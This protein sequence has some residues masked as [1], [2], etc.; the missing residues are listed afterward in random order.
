MVEIGFRMQDGELSYIK[1]EDYIMVTGY[2]GTSSELIIPE[3]IE[4]LPVTHIAKKAFLSKKYLRTVSLPNSLEEV[5][6]WC[7]AYCYNLEQIKFP[8]KCLR[9]GKSIFLE[10][11]KLSKISVEKGTEELLA[12]AVR[13][14]KSYYLLNLNEI[15]S[16]EWYTW[17]DTKCL[18]FVRTEDK[19][20]YVKQILCGEDEVETSNFDVYLSNKRKL[21]SNLVILRLFHDEHLS[22]ENRDIL[23]D[24]IKFHTKGCAQE[25]AW[26]L[27]ISDYCDKP[28]YYHLF[29]HLG[30]ITKENIDGVLADISEQHAEMKAFMLR[31]K[32]EKIGYNDFFG[33]MGLD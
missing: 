20:G 17:W 12:A 32:K 23:Q 16:K 11:N 6:G 10:C 29:A 21:K 1:N 18:E 26:E 25:E 28:E 24:Y 27:M 33:A 31:F 2:T 4:G 15:G 19:D 7:F 3:H 9:L 13:D 14:L 5:G 22:Q 30:C 8:K